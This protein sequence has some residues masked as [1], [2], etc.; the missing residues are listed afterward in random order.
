MEE[1]ERKKERAGRESKGKRR[2]RERRKRRER[3]QSG[4]V[5]MQKQMW[6]V[7]NKE[8][9]KKLEVNKEIRMTK[10]IDIYDKYDR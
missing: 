9:R 10:Y 1:R 4:N 6:E 5:S 2:E 3:G 8:R 7:I